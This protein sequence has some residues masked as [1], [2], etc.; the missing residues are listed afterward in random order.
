MKS[1]TKIFLFTIRLFILHWISDDQ[2]FE[3]CKYLL[4]KFF[5]PNFQQSE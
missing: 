1:D 4:C 5:I 3:I 2:R